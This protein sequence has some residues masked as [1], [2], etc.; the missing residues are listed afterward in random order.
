MR[1]YFGA[2]TTRLDRD[3]LQAH[4]PQPAAVAHILRFGADLAT[5]SG[6]DPASAIVHRKF[7]K[8]SLEQFTRTSLDRFLCFAANADNVRLQ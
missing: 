3:G 7:A 2:Q 6:V 8:T 1:P 4:F 5:C